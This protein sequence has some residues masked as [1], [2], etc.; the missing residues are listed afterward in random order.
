MGDLMQK[1]VSIIIPNF[2]GDKFLKKCFKSIDKQNYSNL[3][4]II[5]DNGSYDG[6]KEFLKR[7]TLF[8]NYN[9]QCIFNED[10]LGFAVAVNQGIKLSDADYVCLINNDIEL[11]GNFITS[12]VKC[13]ESHDNIFSVSSKMLQYHNRDLIDDAGDEYN[14]FAWAKKRGLNK[15]INKY[16]NSDEIFSSCAGAAIYKKVIFNEIGFFD[17]FFFAYMEDVD[18]SFRAKIY[19]YKNMFCPNSVVY[20]VGSA[21]SGSKYNEFKT[22][23]APRNNVLVVYKNM[24]WPQIL[25]NSVFLFLGF[26][27]KY[28]F[29]LRK[30]LGNI[31]LK[32]LKEGIKNR[33]S[34]NK[35]E[36]QQKNLKNYFKIE[37]ELIKNTFFYIFH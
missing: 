23:L 18:I 3:D 12:I 6:S 11:E 13:L 17:E 2:N 27:I 26:F 22:N 29:F 5:I 37:W 24:P 19:G 8:K 7:N 36:F 32:S 16:N 14:L 34:V 20:H 15:S 35:V 28:L 25:I 10:N 31:Y 4:I 1:K 9:Y 33:K 30:G 21:S